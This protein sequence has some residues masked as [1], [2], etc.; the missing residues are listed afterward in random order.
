MRETIQKAQAKAA[1][2]GRAA[3]I[4]HRQEQRQL[5]DEAAIGAMLDQQ[6]AARYVSINGF[7]LDRALREEAAE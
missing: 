3:R 5:R 1:K 7:G 2:G 4:L 6:W